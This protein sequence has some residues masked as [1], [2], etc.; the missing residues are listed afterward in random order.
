MVRQSHRLRPAVASVRPNQI[1]ALAT[2]LVSARQPAGTEARAPFLRRSPRSP[3]AIVVSGS[4]RCGS[5]CAPPPSSPPPEAGSPSAVALS[6]AIAPALPSLPSR[7]ALS[8]TFDPTPAPHSNDPERCERAAASS[9]ARPAC[10][11][12]QTAPYDPLDEP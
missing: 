2:A 3:A 10:L 8:S 4:F 7:A 1:A 5:A 12:K 11:R 6:N 9:S